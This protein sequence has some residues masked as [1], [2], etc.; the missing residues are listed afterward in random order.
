MK[1][2]LSNADDVFK[3]L[4]NEFLLGL[5]S[6]AEFQVFPGVYVTI[7]ETVTFSLCREASKIAVDLK[8]AKPTIR[9]GLRKFFNVTGTV[10]KLL[11]SNNDIV[12]SIDGLPDITVEKA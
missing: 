12:I 4:Y 10:T 6:K 5:L 1:I 8:D 9:V 7:P 3:T 11:I 2:S